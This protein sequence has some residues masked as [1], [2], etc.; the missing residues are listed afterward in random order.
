M[1]FVLTPK[2]GNNII[3]PFFALSSEV[4]PFFIELI[5]AE[6]SII[7]TNLVFWSDTIKPGTN[8]ASGVEFRANYC[9]DRVKCDDWTSVNTSCGTNS[10]CST[11]STDPCNNCV[12]YKPSNRS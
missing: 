12:Y 1:I 8:D 10:I 5:L 11:F 2:V 7:K 9:S 6:L 3:A 4:S